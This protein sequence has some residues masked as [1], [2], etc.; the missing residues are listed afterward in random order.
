MGGVWVFPGGAVDA[1]EGDGDEAAPR[2]RDPRA[3]RGGRRSTLADPGAL[4]E[5]LALDHARRR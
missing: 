5:V 1:D 2:R 4:V 3:A